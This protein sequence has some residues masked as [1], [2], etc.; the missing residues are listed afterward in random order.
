M[1]QL[2]MH[3]GDISKFI[4][5]NG[6]NGGVTWTQQT[7]DSVEIFLPEGAEGRQKN[8]PRRYSPVTRPSTHHEGT[9]KCTLV[10]AYTFH[11]YTHDPHLKV[12]CHV[13]LRLQCT[14]HLFYE[15]IYGTVLRTN[16][17]LHA[18]S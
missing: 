6:P 2:F 14:I 15:E 3:P 12:K 8:I 18:K 16:V 9:C 13:R 1:N 10:H 7:A 17:A 4:N 5:E 11:S